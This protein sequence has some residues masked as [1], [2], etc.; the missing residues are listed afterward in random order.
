MIKKGLPIVILVISS[1]LFYN[2]LM[3][4]SSSEVVRGYVSSSNNLFSNFNNQFSESLND[5]SGEIEEIVNKYITTTEATLGIGIKNTTTGQEYYLN[6]ELPFTAASLYK[7]VVMYSAFYEDKLGRLDLDDPTIAQSL[8]AMISV[9]S[10]DSAI[11]L[12]EK[13]GWSRV[14]EIAKKIGL[15]NTTFTDPPTTTPEDMTNLL[16]LIVQ[17]RALDP[18]NSARMKELLLR[19]KINDRIPALLPPIPI[20]HK[21]GELGD[22]RHDVGIVY[23]DKS[24]YIITLMSKEV[25]SEIEIKTLMAQLSL[26]IYNLFER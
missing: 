16:N 2:Y 6:R 1:F 20:A 22:V 21:T 18:E 13:I 5:E 26:D 14:S 4:H 11:F 19:Q 3:S 10:N 25:T 7:L 12:A 15:K 9:S 24:T 23:G 8:E 17:N